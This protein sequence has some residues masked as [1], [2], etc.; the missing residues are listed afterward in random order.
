MNLYN[1]LFVRILSLRYL[2]NLNINILYD[3]TYVRSDMRNQESQ[4]LMI[5]SQDVH[6]I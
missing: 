4:R 6:V 1:N 3:L 5:I 2:D